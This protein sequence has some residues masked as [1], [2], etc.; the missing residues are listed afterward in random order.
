MIINAKY[1]D[2]L[3]FICLG[4]FAGTA[5]CMKWMEGSFQSNGKLFTIIGLEIIYTKEEMNEIFSGLTDKVETILRFHLVFDYAFMLGVYPGLALLCLKAREKSVGH[6]LR[7][8]LHFLALAQVIALACDVFE[9][10]YL[11]NWIEEPN[12]IGDL[13]FYHTVVLIKWI[14][15]LTAAIVAI[16]LML[17]K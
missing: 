6:V 1:R 8:S 2:R 10:Y 7:R 9:N 14:V 3:L 4:I 17:R 5:F 16:P 15:A 13:T 12:S 11:L